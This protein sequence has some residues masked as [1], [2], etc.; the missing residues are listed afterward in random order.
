[1]KESPENEAQDRATS[2]YLVDRVVPML[3]ERLSKF[4]LKDI[5][6]TPKRFRFIF[7]EQNGNPDG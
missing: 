2:V 4:H 3:P 5:L 1:M 6:Q 7:C